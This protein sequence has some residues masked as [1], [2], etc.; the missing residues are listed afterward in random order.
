[1]DSSPWVSPTLT[2]QDS[3]RLGASSPTKARQ[4]NSDTRTYHIQAT[5]FGIASAPVVQGPH[6]DQAVHSLHV[7]GSLGPA[8]YVLF[9]VYVHWL[10]VQS[11]RAPRVQVS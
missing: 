7:W 2:L 9:P 10:M 1:M 6:E 5:A 3:A 11:M 4:G 8:E